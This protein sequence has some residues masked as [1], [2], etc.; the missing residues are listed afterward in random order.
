MSL[1]V[2]KPYTVFCSSN[3]VNVGDWLFFR[4]MG[5]YTC[6]AASTFNGFNKP[7]K[8]YTISSS[9]WYVEE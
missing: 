5:A 4:N 3:Q 8:Y 1:N 7:P 6:S 2:S 9:C